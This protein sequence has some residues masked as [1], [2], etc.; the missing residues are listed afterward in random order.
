[1]NK[2]QSRELDLKKLSEAIEGFEIEV[3]MEDALLQKIGEAA[4]SG[5]LNID[6]NIYKSLKDSADLLELATP[7]EEIL[8]DLE[9]LKTF[10]I[11]HS[12]VADSFSEKILDGLFSA[13]SNDEWGDEP[14]SDFAGGTNDDEQDFDFAE[15]E[16]K[17]PARLDT[18]EAIDDQLAELKSELSRTT[19]IDRLAQ[20]SL[21]TRIDNLMA[22]RSVLKGPNLPSIEALLDDRCNLMCALWE[23]LDPVL[24]AVIRA[25]GKN[26][27]DYY[28]EGAPI[29]MLRQEVM[30]AL[31]E[32][33]MHPSVD[34]ELLVNAS[35][36]IQSTFDIVNKLI[37]EMKPY[38]QVRKLT[39]VCDLFT[40][41]F[42][43]TLVK[44]DVLS[45]GYLI[46]LGD[47]SSE[48]LDYLDTQ[49][50]IHD[51]TSQSAVDQV[52][53]SARDHI[54]QNSKEAWRMFCMAL[55]P[56]VGENSSIFHHFKKQDI[57]D[58]NML[59]LMKDYVIKN[60][61]PTSDEEQSEHQS[62]TAP[63]LSS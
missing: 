5:T 20:F 11:Y 48:S 57:Y 16:S 14:S 31:T 43:H 46:I 52:L 41:D 24:A 39:K 62:K 53:T 7:F 27:S 18:L 30:R 23:Q 29:K 47:Y 22:R 9:F 45:V 58:K 8:K 21:S 40:H 50:N 13:N 61:D 49:F 42:M 12:M 33:V 25:A 26:F 37:S 10:I 3:K 17:P 59:G 6:A 34:F 1:V 32:Q 28:R 15:S 19:P 54:K 56:T 4:S 36:S 63:K 51:P 35:D 44:Y 55:H 2:M 60:N 38:D